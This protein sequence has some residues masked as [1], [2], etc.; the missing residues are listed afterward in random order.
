MSEIQT[1]GWLRTEWSVAI[2]D[3]L[4]GHYGLVFHGD[5]SYFQ[6][7]CPEC[8]R[9]FTVSSE[10]DSAELSHVILQVDRQAAHPL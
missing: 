9:M 4:E 7:A 3:L 6:G 2:R 10:Q 8:G 1:D 5:T